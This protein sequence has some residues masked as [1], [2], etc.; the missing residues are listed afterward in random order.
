MPKPRQ[1]LFLLGR[2]GSGK[3]HVYRKVAKR[4][5]RK[6]TRIDDFPK[7]QSLAELDDSEEAAGRKRQWTK[8][9]PDGGWVALQIAYETVLTKI[10]AE[11]RELPSDAGFVF[12]EL[13]RWDMVRS[14][15]D[16]F[17]PSVLARSFLIYVYC[18]LT[19]CLARNKNRSLGGQSSVDRH[20]VPLER[21]LLGYVEDDHDLLERLGVPYVLID[22]HLNGTA[23][24]EL[25]AEKVVRALRV[26]T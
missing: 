10:D 14:I 18:P 11:L 9:T 24:L 23:H 19:I 22:N 3:S 12:V 1:F 17:S 4:L 25:E 5:P 7:L 6:P 20:E 21:L 26:R 13:A 15:E 2:P 8:K 16:N